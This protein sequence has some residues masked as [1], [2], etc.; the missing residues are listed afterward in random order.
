MNNISRQP[1]LE[2]AGQGNIITQHKIGSLYN[3]RGPSV[4]QGYKKA[5]ELL[6]KVAKQAESAAQ[7]NVGA[8]FMVGLSAK[9]I[10]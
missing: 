6:L 8:Y 4:H 9:E 1:Y 2:A 3:N 10:F 7:Y 5:Y